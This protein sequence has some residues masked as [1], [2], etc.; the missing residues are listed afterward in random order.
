MTLDALPLEV[1]WEFYRYTVRE[2][3]AV[4]KFYV[5]HDAEEFS[6]GYDSELE[7]V[8]IVDKVRHVVVVTTPRVCDLFR[9]TRIHQSM[10][11]HVVRIQNVVKLGV[12]FRGHDVHTIRS[13]LNL[14]NEVQL[15]LD[16]GLLLCV[17]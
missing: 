7:L 11:P 5:A 4:V 17:F 14:F 3:V 8:L 9:L 1:L 6:L 10:L 2:R 16:I 12:K 15:A 13:T